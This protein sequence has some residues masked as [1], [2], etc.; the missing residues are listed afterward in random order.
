M[1]SKKKAH[2]VLVLLDI[3]SI[4]SLWL[5]YHR[6]NQVVVGI[7]HSA[8]FVEFNNRVGFLFIGAALPMVHLFAIFEYFWPKIIE[9]RMVLFNWS[10]VILLIILI[11][12][13]LFV[14][15]RM[16]TY[17]ERAGYLRCSQADHQ[18]SFSTGLVYT[19]NDAV[20]SRLIEEKS[21]SRR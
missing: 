15:T 9:K 18:L 10:V 8:D 13:A 3:F 16:Q 14:P 6:I 11:S 4:I 20:C 1:M 17:V 5:G 12:G 7:T 2:A 21:K 19:K